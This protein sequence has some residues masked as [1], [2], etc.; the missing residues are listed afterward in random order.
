MTLQFSN[1]DLHHRQA[2]Q[3]FL[4]SLQ[5]YAVTSKLENF[6]FINPDLLTQGHDSHLI[7]MQDYVNLKQKWS[8]WN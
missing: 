8:V 3:D 6:V 4:A 5:I 1:L 7:K 2:N